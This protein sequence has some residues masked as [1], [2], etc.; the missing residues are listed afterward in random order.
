MR[1]TSSFARDCDVI[2]IIDDT[3]VISIHKTDNDDDEDPV[4]LEDSVLV[5][6]NGEMDLSFLADNKD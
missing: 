1:D 5:D 3:D 6:D 2:C 4:E